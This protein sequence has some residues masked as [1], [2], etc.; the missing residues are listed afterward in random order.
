[1]KNQGGKDGE[2]LD[3]I[4]K[5][6]EG[7]HPLIPQ[8]IGILAVATFLASYQQKKRKNIVLLNVISRILYILQYCLLGAF[9]GAVLDVLGAGSS[10]VASKKENAWINRHKVL[11]LVLIDLLIVAVGLLLYENPYS[12]L[13]IAGVLLHTSAFWMDDERKIRVVSLTGSPF[14]FVYNFASRAYGSALGDLLTMA[15]ILIAMV[16]YRRK[17]EE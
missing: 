3:W 12:L 14:W 2:I 15:S 9:S 8:V 13:P 11:L 16:R 6:I 5:V 17:K 7:V 10:V 4:N 1:M